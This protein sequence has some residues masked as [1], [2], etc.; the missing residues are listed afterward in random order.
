MLKT[1]VSGSEVKRPNY[2]TI[3]PTEI[4]FPVYFIPIPLNRTVDRRQLHNH[5]NPKLFEAT[6]SFF[7]STLSPLLHHRRTGES[8]LL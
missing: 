5:S 4:R 1:T 8:R 7:F 6:S 3:R 2:K